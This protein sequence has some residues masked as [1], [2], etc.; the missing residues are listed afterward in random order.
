MSGGVL[1]GVGLVFA[2]DLER[3]STCRFSLADQCTPFSAEQDVKQ[4]SPAVT[5]GGEL[6][7]RVMRHLVIAPQFRVV[8]TYPGDLLGSAG[9][10]A[11]PL[12]KAGIDRV[13][14]RSGIGLRTTF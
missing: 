2:S 9:R 8:I 10:P 13:S 7:I 1:G 14:Y 12:V 6:G 11:G 5:A 3:Q 4:T